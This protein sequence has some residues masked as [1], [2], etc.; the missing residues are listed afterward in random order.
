MPIS[1]QSSLMMLLSKL[2]PQ[3][4]RSLANVLKIKI[5]PCHRNLATVFAVWLGVMYAITCFTKW[6]QKTKRFPM[7]RGWSNFITVSILVKSMGSNSK[8][9]VAIMGCIGALAWVPSCWMHCLQ[10][11][12][13]FCICAAIPGYQNWSCSKYSICCW[14][15][16]PAFWWHPFKA[17]TQCAM[18]TMNHIT[19]SN[20]PLG[21]WQ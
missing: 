21:M 5:Y 12:I 18:G 3:S 9:A 15:R 20:L 1:L 4:L 16:C 14:P 7:F 8:G 6:S 17:A 13:A 11:L 19:S 10:L 2:A